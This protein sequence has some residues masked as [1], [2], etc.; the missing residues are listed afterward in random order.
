MLKSLRTQGKG[1]DYSVKD[2][3]SFGISDACEALFAL[4]NQKATVIPPIQS[5]EYL[6]KSYS[7]K[8]STSADYI[9][10]PDVENIKRL[11]SNGL[12]VLHGMNNLGLYDHNHC[13]IPPA[14][15][16]FVIKMS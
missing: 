13:Y 14:A 1:L 12:E 4:S 10:N 16:A 15:E 2:F 9:T 3:Q 7:G 8:S 11:E 5:A 6:K